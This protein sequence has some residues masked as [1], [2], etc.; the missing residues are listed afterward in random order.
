[1]VSSSHSGD[2]GTHSLVDKVGLL[3]ITSLKRLSHI[4]TE[5]KETDYHSK[6]KTIQ[7]FKILN[8]EPRFGLD[9]NLAHWQVFTKYRAQKVQ[10]DDSK[11]FPAQKSLSELLCGEK[12]KVKWAQVLCMLDSKWI[13]Q[14]HTQEAS[15]SAARAV[16]PHSK[17]EARNLY[18]QRISPNRINL[19]LPV[20]CDSLS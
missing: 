14:W 15:A 20:T 9:H 5:R 3:S 6:E 18:R 19:R 1:M 11:P 10:E 17:L 13:W 2:L 4:K 12:S 7:E 8:I 16:L